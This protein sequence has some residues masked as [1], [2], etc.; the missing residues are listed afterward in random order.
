MTVSI[1]TPLTDEE[2]RVL[3]CLAEKAATT[4]EYYPLTLN[5][6]TSVCNQTSNRNPVVHFSDGEVQTALLALREKGLARTV[7]APGS[8]GPK[9]KHILEEA[10]GLDAAA[11]AVLAILMLRGPQTIGEIKGRTERMHS[12]GGLGAVE[13]T[14]DDLAGRLEPLVVRLPRQP[15]QKEER[16]IH[17]L[18]GTPDLEALSAAAA[19]A[20][21]AAWSG[22]ATAAATRPPARDER[23]SQLEAEL[24]ATR[25][26]VAR[27]RTEFDEFRRSFE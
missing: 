19:S 10:L 1:T 23:L 7:S 17:L 15:G 22:G 5:A 21:E 18:S 24:A 27:L 14:L 2:A 11:V 12:F 13:A 4:P 9:Q 8:R 26:E 3:G 20:A 16:W 6:C 25:D